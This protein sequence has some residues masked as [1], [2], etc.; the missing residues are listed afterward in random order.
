MTRRKEAVHVKPASSGT[1]PKTKGKNNT[2]TPHTQPIPRCQIAAMHS[3]LRARKTVNT[4]EARRLCINHP[5]GRVN[6]LRNRKVPIET[7]W[8]NTIDQ[9]GKV[10]RVALYLLMTNP[11]PSLF[12]GS[13]VK[14]E[15][16]RD[17]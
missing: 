4:I 9:Q 10:V 2:T 1:A 3:L 5:A 11:Q 17:L 8:T 6:D 13:P 7:H 12:E 16:S 14:K 15:V